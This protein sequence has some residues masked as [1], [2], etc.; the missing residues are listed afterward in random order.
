MARVQI[1]EAHLLNCLLLLFVIATS[2]LAVTVYKHVFEIMI[3]CLRLWYY[4]DMFKLMLHRERFW[5]LF[6]FLAARNAMLY[7]FFDHSVF[8]DVLRFKVV[9]TDS[10]CYVLYTVVVANMMVLDAALLCTS[11]V[12]APVWQMPGSRCPSTR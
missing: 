5:T 3:F 11:L 10:V 6:G 9:E 1:P 8:F 7:A 4:Y 2:L 12:G